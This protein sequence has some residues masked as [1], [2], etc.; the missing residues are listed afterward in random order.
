[1]SSIFTIQNFFIYVFPIITLLIGW[2][3]NRKQ[4]KNKEITHFSKS[5]YDI[6][7]GL[8]DDFPE[9]QLQFDGNIIT[10]DMK[11][12]KGGFLNTGNKDIAELDQKPIQL[13]LPD[14]CIVK[15]CKVS[16]LSKDFGVDFSISNS[17]TVDF[18]ISDGVL[19]K[20]DFFE[21]TAIVET[22]RQI[23]SLRDE[24]KVG[25][26]KA[27]LDYKYIFL[28][29]EDKSIFKWPAVRVFIAA[30]S[31]IAVITLVTLLSIPRPLQ[32]KIIDKNTNKEVSIYVNRDSDIYLVNGNQELKLF[33]NQIITKEQLYNNYVLYPRISYSSGRSTLHFWIVGFFTLLLFIGYAL[34][35]GYMLFWQKKQRII[36]VIQKD[37]Q[38]D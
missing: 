35:V 32:H 30:M 27:D 13:L 3:W 5:S 2:L 33:S 25:P 18:K 12:L 23:K 8:S 1:M 21:Y 28:G 4:T 22:P 20:N 7:K 37:E 6:G 16:S 19:K 17:K 10:G 29:R 15:A 34:F 9:F 14:G 36:K 11:V 31:I 26:R 38:H 24:I